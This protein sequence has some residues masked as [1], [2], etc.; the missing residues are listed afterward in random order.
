M[1][2]P[3]LTFSEIIEK[4]KLVF[5]SVDDFAF[6]EMNFIIPEDFVFSEKL[7]K[8][9]EKYWQLHTERYVLYS[10]AKAD[11]LLNTPDHR[12]EYDEIT[13]QIISIGYPERTK[14]YEYLTSLNLQ[15]TEVFQKGG[16]GEGDEWYSVKYFPQHDVYIRVDG[17]Y[18]SHNGTEFYEGWGCCSEVRPQEKVITVYE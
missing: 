11:V 9:T 15:Y 7:L 4:L 14:C 2:Q 18:Q 3:K 5:E 12:K 8:D 6:D 16:E 1:N 13:Q 10:K 17:W